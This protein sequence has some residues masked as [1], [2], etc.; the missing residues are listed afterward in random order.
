MTTGYE[1]VGSPGDPGLGMCRK[2]A[3]EM[4]MG[5]SALTGDS[6]DKGRRVALTDRLFA[7]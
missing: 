2:A 7:C 3:D 5:S 6:R 1:R 4:L